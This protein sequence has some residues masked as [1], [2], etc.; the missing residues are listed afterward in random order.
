MNNEATWRRA[1][2]C[3]GLLLCWILVWYRDTGLAMVGIWNRSDTYAHGFVVPLISLWLIWQKRH[4]VARL[5]PRPGYTA[6][7]LMAGCAVLWLLGDL[8]AVNSATQFA[9]TA[10]LVLAVPAVLG[11]Q[12]A[13]ALLFPLAFL[14]FAVPIGDFMMP[15]LMEWTADFTVLALRASGIPV[16]REGQNFVIPSGNWSV[17]E[18][19][20][21]I[22]YLIASVTVGSLFAHL[23]YRSTLR[24]V[25]FVIVS[26][27]VPVLAN[28]LRAYIIVM[29]GHFSGN[30]IATGVDHIIYG[31]VFFGIV[32]MIMFLI[33]ARWSEPEVPDAEASTGAKIS[34]TLAARLGPVALSGLVAAVIAV[35]PH[36]ANWEIKHLQN[37]ANPR[38]AALTAAPDWQAT[39]TPPTDWKPAFEPP[40]AVLQSGFTNAQGQAVG[41]YVGYYRQQSYQR[42]LVSSENMLVT[43]SD[44]AW[45]QVGA[46]KQAITY[47]KQPLAVRATEL[48]RRGVDAQAQ[49]T[50]LVVWQFYWLQGRLTSSD[51]LAKI[52]GALGRL[53]GHGDDGAVVLVY[54]QKQANPPDAAAVLQSFLDANAGAIAA[55]L[56]QTLNQ[57]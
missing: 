51:S 40:S 9:L 4:T 57:R 29:L 17:V 6:W 1:L 7:V 24:R 34:P 32:I 38:L 12:V 13:S 16:Y 47:D 56:Q 33:G 26:V 46:A 53:T 41:L 45:T 49:E 43:T 14:F 55:T 15:Q 25:I 48:R 50:R 21:G 54:T 39:A 8:V 36:V 2:V 10:L 30:K 22:R 19:C 20:S 3:L 11:W 52:Y 37:P 28:W 23:S 27:L 31:W 44:E 35:L 18:A 42:K 5:V